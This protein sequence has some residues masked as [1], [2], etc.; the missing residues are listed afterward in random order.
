VARPRAAD[1]FAT[2]RVRQDELRRERKWAERPEDSSA[3]DPLPMPFD[4]TGV[5]VI[6]I[7][8][9]KNAAG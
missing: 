8:R 2:I 1:D 4:R 9:L 3:P 5:V 6:A 7:R